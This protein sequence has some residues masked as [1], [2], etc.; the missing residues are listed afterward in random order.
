MAVLLADVLC[1]SSNLFLL[2][3]GCHKAQQRKR[4]LA[5]AER[6]SLG[7]SAAEWK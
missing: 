6:E 7:E 4:T 2:V 5:I 1:P 3:T